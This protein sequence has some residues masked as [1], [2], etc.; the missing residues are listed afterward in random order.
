[1]RRSLRRPLPSR[2][3]ATLAL[4]LAPG[5]LAAPIAFDLPAFADE[6]SAAASASELGYPNDPPLDVVPREIAEY[7]SFVVFDFSR[8]DATADGWASGP[9]AKIVGVAD[10]VLK[11][12]ATGDDPYFF[13]PMLNGIKFNADGSP[14]TVA[15]TTLV[16]LRMRTTTTGGGQ[17][18]TAETAFPEYDESRAPRFP[19]ATDGEFNDYL[20]PVETVSPLLRLRLDPGNDAG[21]I[22]I[23]RLELIEVVYKPV[24][25]GVST[26]ADGKLTF[27]LKNSAPTPTRLKLQYLGVDPAQSPADATLEIADDAQ[28][29]LRYPKKA[30]FETVEVVGTQVGSDE[31]ITRRFFA[32]HEDVA[33]A[34]AADAAYVASA[35]TIKNDR[36]E[37]RFAPDASGAEIFRAGKRVAVLTPLLVEDGDG[38]KLVPPEHSDAVLDAALAASDAALAASDAEKA[39]LR[40]NA[41]SRLRPVF[42]SLDAEKA[43]VE[44]ALTDATDA[45]CGSLRFRLDGDVLAFDA[46]AP[47]SVHSPV[48]RVLGPMKQA[49]LSGVEHLEAGEHSSSTADL[50]TPEHVRFAPP[51]LWLTS[52]FMSVVSE[53][54]AAAIL[55]DDPNARA[56]FAVPNFLDGDASSSRFN[57]CAPKVSGKIRFAAPDETIEESVL[58][59]VLERGGLPELPKRPR[60]TAEQ[61][62]LHL[63][64]FEKSRLKMEGGWAHAVGSGLPPFPFDPHYGSDF[65]STIWELTGAL[66]ETPRLDVGGGHIRNYV[67]FLLSGKADLFLRWIN[68]EAAGIRAAQRPDGSFRYSGKFLRG[69]WVD[70]ASGDCGNYLF[71]LLEHWRLTGDKESLNAALKGLAF[72]NELKTPRG[73]QVWELS[74]H[75]PDIMGA[76]RCVLANVWA[77]E[78]TGDRQYLDAAR[79]WALSGVPYVYLWERRPLA[80]NDDPVMLYAT[81]PV[82]GA[83]GWIAPNWIGLPVQWCGLDYAYA[84]LLLAP[85]DKT[86]DWRK[87]AEGIVISAEEQVYPD[88]PFVGLLPDSF[89]LAAQLRNPYNINPCVVHMLRRL[90]DGRPTNVSVVD[91]AGRRVVSPFPARAEGS[92]LKIDA[93]AGTTYQI[94]IDG[95]EIREIKSQGADVVSFD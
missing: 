70:Y 18:F 2:R 11:V 23:A 30:P 35:P 60:S 16:R 12:R 68:G 78:A 94:V 37:V 73:A 17:F 42:R 34:Q 63:A 74:L 59:S 95:K 93:V 22:E 50:E 14:R 32:F 29:D 41:P 24:K 65:V 15:G 81:T 62:A 77:F 19:L 28:I 44:F 3:L 83:T 43:E 55:F 10:G 79:R 38:A 61:E 71:R 31:R 92:T 90:L 46:D 52:P 66:P 4:L 25:F 27:E 48:V 39:A 9:S 26:V 67:S 88:G 64:G 91:V 82:F 76:S 72:V 87:L 5:F 36:L 53:R 84:L 85:R 1:M 54:C 33:D 89:N 13:T 75:T 21:E 40:A 6:A 58:W 20:V 51:A 47:R 49:I 7:R 69:H 80:G 56:I 57:V 86:L 8:P 45:V